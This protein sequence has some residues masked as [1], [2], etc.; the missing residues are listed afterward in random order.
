MVNTAT[1]ALSGGPKNQ[2][3]IKNQKNVGLG[4]I[5]AIEQDQENTT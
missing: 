1:S 4:Q 5:M 3:Y 2:E